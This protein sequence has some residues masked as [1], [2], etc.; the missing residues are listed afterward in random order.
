[1]NDYYFGQRLDYESPQI[2]GLRS[3]CV[4]V[5]DDNGK[6]VVIFQNAEWVARINYRY[7][8]PHVENRS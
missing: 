2:D 4:F 1:M 3:L 5:R 6:A 7:L 8:S